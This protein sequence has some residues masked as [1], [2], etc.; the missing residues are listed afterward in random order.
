MSSKTRIYRPNASICIMVLL[1]LCAASG[2]LTTNA[3]TTHFA[4]AFYHTYDGEISI[5]TPLIDSPVIQIQNVSTDS[6]VATSNIS[7]SLTI[8]STVVKAVDSVVLAIADTIV[9]DSLAIKDTTTHGEKNNT[10]TSGKLLNNTGSSYFSSEVQPIMNDQINSA[11][12]TKLLYDSVIIHSNKEFVYNTLTINNTTS[13]TVKIQV[14]ITSPKGWNMVTTNITDIDLEPLAS[15][16][17]PMRLT[18]GTGNTAIW[19]D[20]RIEYRVNNVV[21]SRKNYFRVKV[22]E[23]SGFKASLPNGNL[24][25]TGY[26]KSITIPVMVR[27]TGNTDGSYNV[28][29]SNEPMGIDV[30][31][32]I[33]LAPSKDTIVM[34][35]FPVSEARYQRLRKEDVRIAVKNEKGEVISMIQGLSRV[36]YLLKDHISAYQ[37]M[38]LQME[39]GVLYNG[40]DNPMQYY[41]ALYGNLDLTPDD[42][43]SFALR[44]NTIARGQ[45]NNNSIMRLDYTGKRW[46]TSIGNIQGIGEFIVDGYGARLGYQWKGTNKAEAYG[47]FRSRVGD[48][49]VF[50]A[51]LQTGYKDRLRFNESFSASIDNV[52]LMN[53]AILSQIAE[54][55]FSDGRVALITGIGTE[56][57]RNELVEGTEAV[58]SGTSLGYNFIWAKP[59]F[60]LSSNVLYNSNSYPGVFKGQRIQLHDARWIF[61]KMFVGAYYEYNFRKQ[62]YF[63]DTVLLKD[64]F[65]LR[66]TNLGGRVGFNFK[67]ATVVLAGGNQQQLQEGEE[68]LKTNYDYLNLTTSVFLSRNLFINLT[69]FAGVMSVPGRGEV[70]SAYVMSNQGTVQLNKVGA[71]FR[72]DN[73]PYYYQEFVAYLTKQDDYRRVM[74]S[75]FAEVRLWK[76][77]FNGRFQANYAKTMPSNV[78]TTNFIANINYNHPRQGFDFNVSGI[79]PVSNSAGINTSSYINA[80]FRMRVKAPFVAIRKYYNLKLVLFKDANGDG[81]QDEDEEAVGGQTISLNGDLF[82]SNAEGEVIY[83]NTEKGSYKAEF[84]FSTKLK[85]WIPSEGNVQYFELTGN[86]TIYIPYK[87]SR[88]LSGKLSVQKDALSD[89]HFNVANIKVIVTAEKGEVNSTLTDEN[90]E[91]HF[92]LPAGNYII[93]LSESAFGDQFKPTEFSQAADLQNNQTVTLYFD[94]KQRKRQINIKKKE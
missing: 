7:D 46:N 28:A 38:P 92:N 16:I 90:G 54:Y 14:I 12:T 24:V 58:L 43:I 10:A 20:V 83:K 3:R 42:R 30:N 74:I 75:P 18:A 93:S 49:K 61:K 85:G 67:K 60:S 47:M 69:S 9:K 70:A 6:L 81:K 62:N 39:L 79:F 57:N 27:N 45:T 15:S 4:A 71:S 13:N 87:V 5:D 22:Q 11:Y 94:I 77:S 91:F 34:L 76:S 8:D 48:S 35:S 2:L 64:V 78:S 82:V 56:H 19:Q 1:M 40:A 36:G 55:N 68:A 26:Q 41:G 17:V 80:A 59:S 66:T 86:K 65:N 88:V 44:S 23:Y 21:D 72:F 33:T 53:S 63:L 25:L 89:A 31:V 32:P 84:G 51:A 52:R 29:L 50:G 37:E 73:G